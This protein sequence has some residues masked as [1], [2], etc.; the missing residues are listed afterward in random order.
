MSGASHPQFD[1]PLVAIGAGQQLLRYLQLKLLY[2]DHCQ[3][4]PGRYQREPA[5]LRPRPPWNRTRIGSNRPGN[6]LRKPALPLWT[7]TFQG[8]D[9]LGFGRGCVIAQVGHRFAQQVAAIITTGR[10]MDV[11]LGRLRSEFATRN[12]VPDDRIG[13]IGLASP[14][15]YIFEI[16]VQ[17][18]LLKTI[19]VA[20]RRDAL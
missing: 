19:S 3:R 17:H 4:Q 12:L 14:Q 13:A 18:A 20:Y 11:L 16:T 8:C 9:L 2:A 5:N 10:V 15:S 7:R 1:G 6:P